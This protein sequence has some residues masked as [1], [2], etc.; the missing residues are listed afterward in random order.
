MKLLARFGRRYA[1]PYLPWYAGGFV[2]L[3]LTN[4]LAVQIPVH[5]AAAIDAMGL[6]P[7]AVRHE[8]LLIALMGL[9]VI[10]V[11]TGSRVLFFTPGRLVE[12][13]LKN[14][15]F[16]QLTKL[17]PA[18]YARLETGDIVSR[19]SNDVAFL[20]ALVGF[21]TLQIC[22]V[23]LALLLTGGE[24]V[25]L[26]PTLTLYVT[27]PILV[28]MLILQVGIFNMHSLVRTAQVQ[29]ADLSDHVLSSLQGIGTIQ[30]F[31]AEDAF[32]QRMDD[33]NRAYMDT[34][35]KLSIIRSLIFPL[36][37]MAGGIGL[38]A[39]LEYGGPMAVRGEVSVGELVA[40]I[41]FIAYLLWP[42]MSLGWL[43][44]VF[45]RGLISLERID[46]LMYATPDRPDLPHPVTPGV[47][48]PGLAIRGLTYR[49][50]ED[51]EE[52]A[53]KDL[54]LDIEAGT[55]VGI[56]GQTGSGKSTLLR[57]LMR[58]RNPPEGTIEVDG[59]DLRKLDLDAWRRKLAVASQV[60]FLFSDSIRDNIAMGGS[61]PV[62]PSVEL[63]ALSGDVEH[64]PDALDTI[65]GERGIMLSGGQ[66]QRTAL[67]R[68]L[69]RDYDVL[70]LDDVLS[71]VDQKTEQRLIDSLEQV[72]TSERGDRGRPTTLLV[73][74]RM[75]VLARADKVVVLA[76]G[77][78]VDEGPHLELIERPG[79]YRDAWL[80]Q[81]D[82]RADA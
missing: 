7:D 49:Y 21:G 69:Y 25:S 10:A 52:P 4:W 39:L 34:N 44:S 37:A 20:R 74:H 68:A 62:E 76:D 12:F 42:L 60:P 11:R 46:E 30:G 18:V 50:G 58:T 47:G 75:S 29:L 22:N 54:D 9:A 17:Q 36:L 1:L 64:L 48:A 8:A 45:Q 27:A 53:L 43:V 66:R 71:A 67:A 63:A 59:V 70:V 77:R 61:D 41:T 33:R 73:S 57:L 23:T 55:V 72:A 28:G 82:G 3:A 6:D 51:D 15:L 40:F 65:V 80:A 5:M 19:A 31:T 35:V 56:Y 24:M 81:D 13:H 79:P 38:W 26:S 14:D 2:F 16:A 78:K 32:I